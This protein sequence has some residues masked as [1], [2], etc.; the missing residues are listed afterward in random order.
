M[1]YLK[2]EKERNLLKEAKL[3]VVGIA[4]ILCVAVAVILFSVI[5]PCYHDADALGNQIGQVEGK[6][7]GLVTGS[8]KG[9]TEGDTK[10][11]EDGL[12]AEDTTATVANRMNEVGDLEVLVAGVSLKN[13]HTVGAKYKALYLLAGD[14]VF[15]VDMTKVKVS[16]TSNGEMLVVIPKPEMQVYIDERKT[17][18]L[19]EWQDPLFN[20][21]AEDGYTAYM[22]SMTATV[23]EMRNALSNYDTLMKTA[24]DSAVK[25]VTV[26]VKSIC[27]SDKGIHISIE[28]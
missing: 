13:I 28:V 7:V 15:T 19:A 6:A 26:L 23:E 5:I 17:S 24:Q 10:G 9:Y 20:G 27:G 12:K 3:P 4:M 18:K 21:S 16:A 1:K 25:Q 8:Y 11:K 14:A 2:E 22:N